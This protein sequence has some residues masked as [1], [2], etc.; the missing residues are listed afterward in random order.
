MN[1]ITIVTAFYDINRESWNY[2]D[3]KTS[4]YFECFKLLC[5]LKNKI[6]VF[7]EEKFKP[8]FEEIKKNYKPDLI[9]FY[10]NIISSNLEFIFKIQ[11]AQNNLQKIGGLYDCGRPPEYWNPEYVLVNFLKS[12][13]CLSAIEQVSDVDDVVA[14]IDFGYLKKQEQIPESKIW[15][16]NFEDKIHLWSIKNIPK[17]I[18]LLST[19]R[20]NTVYIQGC[21]IVCTKNKWYNLNKLMNEQIEYLLSNNLVDDDQ[22]LLLMSYASNPQE[23][24]IH[25]EIIN[26]KDLDWFFI[27]QYYNDCI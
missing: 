26:P 2:Y 8:Y 4:M 3:R 17:E 5:Q 11:E 21:H 23:F 19:I 16:Y 9:V 20:T 14:W 1:N 6:I 24:M 25:N 10:Q 22:T 12:Q 27:F 18:D 7:S 15:K 13:F